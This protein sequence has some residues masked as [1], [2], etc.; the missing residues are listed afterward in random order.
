MRELTFE[1]VFEF[2]FRQHRIC[3]MSAESRARLTSVV[4]WH[5]CGVYVIVA[6]FVVGFEA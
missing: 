5:L 2:N 3:K 6:W 4:R 1:F